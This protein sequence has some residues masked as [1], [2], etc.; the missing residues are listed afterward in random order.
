MPTKASLRDLI[1]Q[2]TLPCNKPRTDFILEETTRAA[3]DSI[4]DQVL[5]PLPA[6]HYEAF[7]RLLETTLD[8]NERLGNLM[9]HKSR[10]GK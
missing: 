1:D 6:E 7:Q 8:E 3:Q 10:W 9:A 5:F 2:A 4:L